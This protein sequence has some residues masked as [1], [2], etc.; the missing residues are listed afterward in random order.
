MRQTILSESTTL[1]PCTIAY[2]W[3]LSHALMVAKENS[4]LARLIFSGRKSVLI[5][6]PENQSD[7]DSAKT[8]KTDS[9]TDAM[10]K[11]T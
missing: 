7:S 4:G 10:I 8:I 9:R 3:N 2:V 11:W 6:D 1:G 5:N